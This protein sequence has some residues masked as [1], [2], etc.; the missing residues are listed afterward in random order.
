MVVLRVLVICE[1]VWREKVME[2]RSEAKCGD[3]AELRC[4]G[5]W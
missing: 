1:M 5:R 4:R 3:D 2:R